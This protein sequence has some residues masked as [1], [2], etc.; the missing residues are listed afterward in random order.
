MNGK[1]LYTEKKG[2]LDLSLTPTAI[3]WLESQ[4]DRLA[5][6]GLSDTIERLAREKKL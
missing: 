2:R 6:R 5:A 1:T 3:A 4:R